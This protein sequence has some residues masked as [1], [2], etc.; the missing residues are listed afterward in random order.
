MR[1]D[2]SLQVV[3]YRVRDVTGEFAEEDRKDSVDRLSDSQAGM[4]S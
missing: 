1:K 4:A 3:C 2:R